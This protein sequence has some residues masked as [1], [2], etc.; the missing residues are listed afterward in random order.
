MVTFTA[1]VVSHA[2]PDAC[3]SILGQLRYQTRPADETIVLC[4]DTP[5]IA[6]LR[7]EFPEAE[8][9]ER[10]N[11]DDW[12][13]EKRAEGLE[14]ATGTFVGFFNDDDGY[15]RSYIDKMLSTAKQHQ[16]DVVYC[17][18]NEY[19]DCHFGLGSSTAGNFIVRTALAQQVGWAGRRYEADG[20]FIDAVGDRTERI[21]KVPEPLYTHNTFRRRP[22]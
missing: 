11:R 14:R 21:V 3:R 12:G 22:A 15:S 10:P 7:E 20:D 13:H 1:V 9:L 17:S 18:W 8:F 2:A 16:A 6:R 19:P 5:D 4:S